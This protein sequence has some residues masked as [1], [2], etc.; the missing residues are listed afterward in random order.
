V[1][2]APVAATAAAELLVG[3]PRRALAEDQDLLAAAGRLVRKA[4]TPMDN[5][6]FQAQWRGVMAARYTEAAL[7]ELAGGE[8][9]RL[10]SRHALFSP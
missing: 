1:G 7:R 4:A 10:A 5:T 6:D 2:S 8:P 9:Q 3:Q